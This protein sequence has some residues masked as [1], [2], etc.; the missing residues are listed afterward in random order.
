MPTR[1]LASLPPTHGQ[2]A[3]RHL[4]GQTLRG[5]TDRAQHPPRFVSTV[6]D[7]SCT[8]RR[9]TSHADIPASTE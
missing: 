9:M 6:S 2:E 4:T 8:V 5:Q 3:L 7:R 1:N